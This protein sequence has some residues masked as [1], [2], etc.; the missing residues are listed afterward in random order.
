[1]ENNKVTFEQLND[2][3]SL[4]PAAKDNY[5]D[6]VELREVFLSYLAEDDFGEKESNSHLLTWGCFR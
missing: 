2:Q 3:A 1:M 6:S 5:L 4:K